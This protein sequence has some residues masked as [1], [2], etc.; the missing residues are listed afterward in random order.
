MLRIQQKL[1][2]G[3]VI[4]QIEY[5]FAGGKPIQIHRGYPSV[6]VHPHGGGV[7]DELCVGMAVQIF[8]V[9]WAIA[10][11]ANRLPGA[12]IGQHRMDGE[13]RSTGPQHQGLLS[14]YL[15]PG[16]LEQVAEP[17][18]VRVIS[19]ESPVRAAEK[20]VDAADSPGSGGEGITAGHHRL[21]IGDGH[22]DGLELP[23]LQKGAGVCLGGQ[24]AQLVAVPAEQL[25]DG[26]GVGV[27]Q[28]AADESV[29]H[30][31]PPSGSRWGRSS[32][33]HRTGR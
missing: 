14:L 8:V 12:Q 20:G 15:G 7:D 28:L 19:V 33:G 27:S 6:G 11:D 18:V 17:V 25:M 22:I 10:G 13:G 23:P 3:R 30:L 1:G 9:V 21:F 26:L 24:R 29:F 2:S 5:A 31:S 32:T 16:G 4:D